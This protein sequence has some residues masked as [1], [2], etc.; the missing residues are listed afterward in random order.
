VRR[1]LATP[2]G[3]LCSGAIVGTLS[4]PGQFHLHGRMSKRHLLLLAATACVAAAG[5]DTNYTGAG[6]NC[7]PGAAFECTCDDGSSGFAVCED[8]EIGACS[9]GS[10]RP[11]PDPRPIRLG[12]LLVAPGALTVDTGE[13]STFTV[14]NVGEDN[15]VYSL[16]LEEDDTDGQQELY[17]TPHIGSLENVI[18]K[19][20]EE[21][22]YDVSYIPA[23]GR[24]GGRVRIVTDAGEA[25]VEIVVRDSTPDIDGPELVEMGRVALGAHGERSFTVINRGGGTLRIASM[26]VDDGRREFDFCFRRP[27]QEV[28]V[29]PSQH[30]DAWPLILDRGESAR[31]Y[32]TYTPLDVGADETMFSIRSNDPDESVFSFPV[33]ALATDTCAE[34]RPTNVDFGEASLGG[35]ATRQVEFSNC[36]PDR[37]LRL[38]DVTLDGDAFALAS[39]F[40]PELAPGEAISMTVTFAPTQERRYEGTLT[41][42]SNDRHSS[43]HRIPLQGVGVV[44]NVC[45][46]AVIRARSL[47]TDDEWRMGTLNARPLDTVIL[48]GSLSSDPDAPGQPQNGIARYEWRIV[49]QPEDSGAALVPNATA[50]TPNMFL[51]LHGRYVV[52]LRVY[53]SQGL[54]T[55][56][57]ARVTIHALTDEDIHVQLVWHTPGDSD[58]RDDFGSDLDLHFLHPRGRWNFE[59]WDC[60]WQNTSPNW[61]APGAGDDPGLDIDDTTGAGPE[62]IN[63]TNPEPVEYEIGVFYYSD[64][65]FGP[66]DVTI[67]VFLGGRLVYE[68]LDRPLRD[69][70]FWQVAVVDWAELEVRDMDNVFRGFP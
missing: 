63:L 41:L 65:S 10:I 59:P 5:C 3:R 34:V 70:Q 9:C 64:A 52:E 20:T 2:I 54:E 48:D 18:I 62:N 57:P 11:G 29:C 45:P 46:A 6:A 60:H 25:V 51:D 13:P 32:I 44:H 27:G 69:Q 1:V 24:N 53:D 42:I 56:E 17:I 31:V 36:S 55:C 8:D 33:T 43:P 66:S 39:P 23:A 16:T 19:P 50:P 68:H 47:E 49:E 38:R 7:Y 58:E 30:P 4:E 26:E 67:R 61:G 40:P 14:T 37:P 22:G 35:R 21:L 15:E 12:E 28:E